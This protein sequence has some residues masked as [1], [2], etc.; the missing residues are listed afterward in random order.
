MK[1][2]LFLSANPVKAII[3]DLTVYWITN[4]HFKTVRGSEGNEKDR[5]S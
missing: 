5:A 1:I 3:A 2:R 4:D